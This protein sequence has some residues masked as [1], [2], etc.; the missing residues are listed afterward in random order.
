MITPGGRV[1]LIL[2]GFGVAVMLGLAGLAVPNLVP[3]VGLVGTWEYRDSHHVSTMTLN[4]DGTFEA[5]QVPRAV[6]SLYGTPGFSSTLDW[7]DL[8]DL[9]GRWSLSAPGEVTL[10]IDSGDLGAGV[11]THVFVNGWGW[12]LQ[13]HALYGSADDGRLLAFG[14]R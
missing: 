12:I 4:S 10:W 13:L 5:E 7:S 9:Q 2:G 3:G 14:R 6:F 1:F 8:V 11:G